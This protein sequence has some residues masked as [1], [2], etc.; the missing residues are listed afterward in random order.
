MKLIIDGLQISSEEDFHDAIAKGLALP[1]WY[2]KNLDALWDAL[3]GMVD[4]PV[5]LVWIHAERSKR[6]LPRYEKIVSLLK[7][8]EKMDHESGRE[9]V[10]VLRI[11]E[12]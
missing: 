2:G 4:R 6:K 7:D 1:A 8:V 10:F 5:E 9:E 12:N 11:V 3:T